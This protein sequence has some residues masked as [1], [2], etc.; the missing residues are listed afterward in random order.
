MPY[1]VNYCESTIIII[2]NVVL[3]LILIGM[4]KLAII[5]AGFHILYLKSH[6]FCEHYFLRVGFKTYNCTAMGLSCLPKALF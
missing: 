6:Y 4:V 5:E 3:V 1:L 2:I